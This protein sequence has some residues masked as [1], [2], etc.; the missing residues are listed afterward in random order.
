MCKCMYICVCIFVCM[1]Q[2]GGISRE[3]LSVDTTLTTLPVWG[4]SCFCLLW[5]CCYFDLHQSR[6][7]FTATG[8]SNGHFDLWSWTL[9]SDIKLPS[10]YWAVYV[11]L[12]NTFK[13]TLNHHSTTASHLNVRDFTDDN[14]SGS[15]ALVQVKVTTCAMQKQNQDNPHKG[16]GSASGGYRQLLS[17]SAIVLV[18]TGSMRW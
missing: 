10:L 9:Y 16:N 8:S 12:L 11:K 13:G 6:N 14:E 3:Q 4:S 1:Y 2:S 17:C 15:P 5:T 18:T 7:W